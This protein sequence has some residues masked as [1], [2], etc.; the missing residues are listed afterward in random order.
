MLTLQQ[1]IFC[2]VKCFNKIN[3]K[4]LMAHIYVN[5]LF[6]FLNFHFTSPFVDT[7]AM[8]AIN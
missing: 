6:L 2:L 1:A 4:M 3:I 5:F 8:Y 7:N